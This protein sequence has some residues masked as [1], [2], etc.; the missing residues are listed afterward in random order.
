MSVSRTMRNRWAPC[1]V[2]PGNSMPI[3]SLTTSSRKTNV[4]P[5]LPASCAGNGMNRG[6]TSGSLTRANRVRPAWLTTTARFMLRLEMY[7]NGCPGSNARGV[8]TG[9]TFL[10]K[11]VR[12]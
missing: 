3:C 4:S 2:A 11:Y 8:S 9:C 12:R 10:R 7:G 1:S 5:G 6:S